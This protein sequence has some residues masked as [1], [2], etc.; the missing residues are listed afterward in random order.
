MKNVILLALIS[1]VQTTNAQWSYLGLGGIRVTDLIVYSDTLYASTYDGIYKKYIF[2]TDTAWM[3]CG[4]QRNHVVQTL[5]PNDRTFICAIEVDSTRE[6]IILVSTSNDHR[7]IRCEVVRFIELV[8][9]ILAA[10]KR[11]SSADTTALEREIDQLVYK[12]GVYPADLSAFSLAEG[13]SLTPEEI[14]IVEGTAKD[15]LR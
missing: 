7:K 4:M 8:G 5:V 3:R 12:L 2:N 15:K 1:I 9:K 11:D 6:K 10:K 14:A 13:G